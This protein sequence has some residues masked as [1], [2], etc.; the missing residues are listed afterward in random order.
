MCLATVIR[1][2]G[3]LLELELCCREKSC[4]IGISYGSASGTGEEK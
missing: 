1:T 4:G 2:F 3:I